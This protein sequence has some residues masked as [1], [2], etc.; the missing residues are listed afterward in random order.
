M[1]VDSGRKGRNGLAGIFL[2]VTVIFAASAWGQ[3][4]KTYLSSR[5]RPEGF[6]NSAIEFIQSFDADKNGQVD[7][8]E[9]LKAYETMFEIM[10]TSGDGKIDSREMQYDPARIYGERARW[11]A[12]IVARY[13]AD[14]DGTLSAEEAPFWSVTFTRADANKDEHVDKAELTQFA[15]DLELLRG[16]LQ[17]ENPTKVAAA[18]LKKYDNNADGKIA[19]AEF[20]WGDQVFGR[21]DRD[22]NGFLDQA[23]MARIPP[24]PPSPKARAR[25]ML[26]ERD[27]DNSGQLSA[28]EFDEAP[29]RFSAADLNADGQL[30]LD[31]LTAMLNPQLAVRKSSRV[32][33][34]LLDAPANPGAT[35][36]KPGK[37]VVKAPGLGVPAVRK[38][39]P[40]TPGTPGG[41]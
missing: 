40:K 14:D 30:S 11:A 20:E 3:Y 31:E 16:G 34:R 39:E 18:F 10:D 19:P 4:S 37:P 9:F 12:G 6:G 8:A 5:Y 17:A 33:K 36:K 24:L 1:R 41:Q 27:K 28:I 35:L 26:K 7:R 15:F 38:V 2:L 23:E 13:D 29:E 32:E 21:Y 25:D 22:Q